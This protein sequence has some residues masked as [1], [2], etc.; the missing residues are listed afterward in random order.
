MMWFDKT[1][2]RVLYIDNRDAV[3]V[4]DKRSTPCTKGR[5]PRVVKPDVVADFRCIP[6]GDDT[7]LHVVF[8]PPHLKQR[9]NPDSVIRFNYGQ[10]DENWKDG[11][12]QG[13]AECFRVLK[14]GGTL[15]FK[16]CETDIKVKEILSLTP[17]KPLYG[18]K[19]GK[20]SKTHWIVFIKD[21]P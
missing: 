1:D 9:K 21:K 20:A 8:D 3:F 18:H 12:R 19:S 2:P 6:Y 11:I 14:V 16:W 10:L 4:V 17:I 15:I 5:S 13:F 7:F